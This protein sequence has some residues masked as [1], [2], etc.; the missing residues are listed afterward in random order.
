[1]NKEI[2]IPKNFLLTLMAQ[3]EFMNF[4]SNMID[5]KVLRIL[6]VTQK[7]ACFEL[8]VLAQKEHVTEE[9]V[10]VIHY[11]AD[12][13]EEDFLDGLDENDLTCIVKKSFGSKFQA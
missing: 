5:Y 11:S 13:S 1:M 6:R 10:T 9:I 12:A 4:L 3:P 2:L 7:E 8:N